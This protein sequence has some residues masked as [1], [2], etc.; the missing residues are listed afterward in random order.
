[1]KYVSPK[2]L[3]FV[4]ILFLAFL[5]TAYAA[6]NVQVKSS[7]KLF[8]VRFEL[9]PIK[10]GK[11]VSPAH[12]NVVVLGNNFHIGITPNGFCVKE[13][14]G[15]EFGF[16]AKKL[17]KELFSSKVAKD[18]LANSRINEFFSTLAALAPNLPRLITIPIM[19]DIPQLRPIYCIDN[20]CPF[21]PRTTAISDPDYCK[22]NPNMCL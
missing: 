12:I 14:G 19:I 20:N 3:M 16:D 2:I 15:K 13:L 1:M 4:L 10:C 11:S 5:P 9:K 18:L 22:K 8:E 17:L 6:G 21:A 7:G